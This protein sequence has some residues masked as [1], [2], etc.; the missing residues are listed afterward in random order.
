MT[1]TTAISNIERADYERHKAT[2][3]DGLQTF[4]EGGLALADIHERK[5]YRHEYETFEAFIVTEYGNTRQWAYQIMTTADIAKRLSTV[6]DTPVSQN[7]IREVKRVPEQ[8]RE[9]V[10]QM[11]VGKAKAE[12]RAPTGGDV[13]R[14]WNM[15]D[16]AIKTGAATDDDGNST[17][18][19]GEWDR[20]NAEAR[21]R[22]REHIDRAQGKEFVGAVTGTL[23]R[24]GRGVYALRTDGT[25][26][27]E[28]GQL[29]EISVKIIR[30][31][32]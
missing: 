3:R 29:V 22:Q 15:V 4:V 14:T 1:A 5:L 20:E 8:H 18:F 13:K 2:I 24:A 23:T 30:S 17:P 28:D 25:L 32:A 21:Q 16:T 10:A 9:T 12:S 19:D 6:V 11:A 31:A 27:V 7:F 26:A